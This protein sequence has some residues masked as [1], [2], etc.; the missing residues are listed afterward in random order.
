MAKV[1]LN[2]KGFR[3]LLVTQFL[4]AFNDNIYKLVI[5]FLAVNL[6][7]TEK[8]GTQYLALASGIFVL[9]FVIFSPYAGY[10]ADRFSKRRILIS[11][12]FAEMIIMTLGLVAFALN[13]VWVIFGCLFL[14]G[15]QS[16]F[17]SP[18]K[19]G[20]LPEMLKDE[21]LSEGN[22]LIQMW[23]Y[24]A[25]ICGMSLGGVLYQVSGGELYKVSFLLIF[26]SMAGFMTSFSIPRVKPSG[27]KRKFSLNSLREISGTIDILRK[28]R[29]IYLAALGTIYFGFLGSL[30]HLNILLYAKKVMLVSDGMAGML[31]AIVAVGIGLGSVLAGK[32]SG[33][34]IE[35][36]LVPLG[37]IIL[38]LCSV[39]LGFT[40]RSTA[41]T[42][43]TLF[44]MGFGAGFYVVPLNA[45]IQQRAPGERRGQVLAT[46]NIFSFAGILFAS[47]VI[48]LLRDVFAINAAAIFVVL[49]VVSLVVTGYICLLLPKNLVRLILWLKKMVVRLT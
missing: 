32:L 2:S 39:R 46:L 13:N 35:F 14:M 37:A 6:F 36:G 1:A 21:D 12:K 4:G 23:T 28:D 15:T 34:K 40:Y 30:F 33:K 47:P 31:F 45:F 29:A 17:F 7:V 24:L 16:T 38:T 25:I 8:A 5:A 27:A 49:G 11:A 22:G 48:W 10:L 18:S 43:L 44:L 41:Q 3:G 9:P 20:I 19:Y 26:L 42:G